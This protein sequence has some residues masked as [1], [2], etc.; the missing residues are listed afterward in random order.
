MSGSGDGTWD[1][2][3]YATGAILF[4]DDSSRFEMFYCGSPGSPWRPFR[5]GF[6]T[7]VDGINWI[8]YAGNP[9]LVPD[10]G[11]WDAGSVEMPSVIREN[12]LYKMWYS[13]SPTPNSTEDKIGYATSPDGI[14][15]TKD[16]HNPVF[17]PGSAAWEAGGV[18]CPAV[19]AVDTG[20]YVMWYQGW[21]T[22]VANDQIGIAT[23]PDGINWQ[24][25]T[26]HNPVLKQGVSPEWDRAGVVWPTVVKTNDVYY[27]YYSGYFTPGGN[28]TKFG[29]ATSTDEGVTWTKYSGNPLLLPGSSGTWESSMICNGG[30]L[31][32]GDSLFY[33]WYSGYN[34]SLWKI[35]LATSP[36]IPIPVEL[37]SFTATSN[38]KEVLLSWSTATELNNLGFEV[39]RSVDQEEFFTVGFVNGH[40][41]TTEKHNYTF[42]DRSLNNGKNYYRLK[43]VDYDGRY[44]YSAVIEV[45][46]S[47]PL[48]FWLEQNYPNPFNPTTTIGYGIKG[49]NNV[50]ITILNAIGEEVAVILNEVKEPGFHQVEFNAAS[51]PSGVYLYRL[52]AG[53]FVETK[54]MIL[55]R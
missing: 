36:F 19:L 28:D 50:K 52:N 8:K 46:V 32:V 45:E 39:Q 4:N 11:T 42:T 14:N 29:L 33:L 22:G 12:G 27:M 1:K 21:D 37:S 55:L 38:G 5:I 15:W 16:P 44:E 26:I 9:V 49:K 51:L 25:D 7:S 24:R 30:A 41:T 17:V 35:G 47:A 13:G 2:H 53:S 40:G 6:A 43:Q 31:L 54:K 48:E 18:Y 23:S 3:V 34:G 20:G 10:P